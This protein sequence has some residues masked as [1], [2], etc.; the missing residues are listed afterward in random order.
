MKFI[1][2]VLKRARS[3]TEELERNFLLVV[4]RSSRTSCLVP[5]KESRTLKKRAEGKWLKVNV[6]DFV[7]YEC[8]ERA[9][10]RG[11][12]RNTWL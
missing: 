1:K 7:I 4:G 8:K 2:K 10:V 12:K 11:W 5:V 6:L 3:Q 9:L